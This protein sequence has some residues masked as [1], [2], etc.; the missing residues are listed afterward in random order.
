MAGCR[1][2]FVEQRCPPPV[3][4]STIGPL[5][6]AGQAGAIGEREL[7]AIARGQV[8]LGQNV[9]ESGADNSR[10]R[11]AEKLPAIGIDA[12]AESADLAAIQATGKMRRDEQTGIEGVGVRPEVVTIGQVG[13]GRR[14]LQGM[15]SLGTVR[16][17]DQ[18]GA[19]GRRQRMAT[20]SEPM[21]CQIGIFRQSAAS[22]D[23]LTDAGQRAFDDVEFIVEFDRQVVDR[24]L[25]QGCRLGDALLVIFLGKEKNGNVDKACREK[26]QQLNQVIGGGACDPAFPVL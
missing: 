12:Q 9:V 16:A 4:R 18:D 14:M 8:L 25:E 15:C 21:Q 6:E 5:R 7:N 17:D 11:N 19:H 23:H 3:F 20:H 13:G 2:M 22:G 10:Q 24:A 1:Q 26:E